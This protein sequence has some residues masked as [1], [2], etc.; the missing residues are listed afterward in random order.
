MDIALEC[1]ATLQG[2]VTNFYHLTP[3]E[4]KVETG[5]AAFSEILNI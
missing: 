4:T 2:D 1:L 3:S 5:F